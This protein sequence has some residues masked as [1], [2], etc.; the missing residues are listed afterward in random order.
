MGASV[1]GSV[2]AS[3]GALD[4]ADVGGR[5]TAGVAPKVGVGGRVMLGRLAEGSD[6][7]AKLG[8]LLVVGPTETQAAEIAATTSMEI[9]TRVILDTIPL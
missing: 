8:L 4:G 6:G 5:V 9:E 1:G 3:V 2:G 7:T